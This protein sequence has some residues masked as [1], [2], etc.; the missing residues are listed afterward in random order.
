VSKA[1]WRLTGYFVFKKIWPRAFRPTPWV[2]RYGKIAGGTGSE[3]PNLKHLLGPSEALS[4]FLMSQGLDPQRG[5]LCVMPSSLW[6]G[7][8]W[9]VKKFIEV[10][11]HLPITPVILGTEKDLESL[12]LIQELERAQIPHR[13]GVGKWNL[14]QVAQVLAGSQG[15]FGNDTGLAH[16]A[17]A[18][19]VRATVVFGPTAAD[20]GFG[21]WREESQSL[22]RTDLGCRPCGKDG[23]F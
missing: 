21:P 2:Q 13:S 14:K 6:E 3:R 12:E 22:G 5:Y 8:K 10:L 16:L 19:G 9:P 4:Q 18:V 17:E 1:R 7:K 23:R 11:K 15:Y 20:M